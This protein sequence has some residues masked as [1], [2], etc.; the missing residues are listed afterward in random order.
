MNKNTQKVTNLQH[1]KPKP[2]PTSQLQPLSLTQ[3]DGV[4]GGP[5]EPVCP[6]CCVNN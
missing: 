5:S 2:Q 3:L 1:P 4:A 6:D